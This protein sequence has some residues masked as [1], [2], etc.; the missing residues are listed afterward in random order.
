MGV[1]AEGHKVLVFCQMTKI[2]DIICILYYITYTMMLYIDY[3]WA[4]VQAEGHKVLMFCQMTKMMDI[5]EDYFWYRKHRR[6]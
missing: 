2:I 5:L 6:V 3:C 4:G 1:Q